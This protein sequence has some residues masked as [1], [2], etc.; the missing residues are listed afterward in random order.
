[1]KRKR[2]EAHNG[3][4][5]RRECVQIACD[6]FN[7]VFYSCV[8]I[9]SHQTFIII[10]KVVRN[11]RK[12]KDLSADRREKNKKKTNERNHKSGKRW[13]DNLN[14][15]IRLWHRLV[16]MCTFETH[17]LTQKYT[18]FYGTTNRFFSAKHIK[19]DAV[20][21]ERKKQRKNRVQMN[22][23]MLADNCLLCNA[24]RNENN[25]QDDWVKAKGFERRQTKRDEKKREVS[26]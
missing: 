2:C 8:W 11:G 1:M 18:I 17:R 26:H 15:C 23:Q 3:R 24:K 9:F 21:S 5:G 10:V 22:R 7:F 13:E 19:S 16:F 6:A 14:A 20:K 25:C 12:N 4:R